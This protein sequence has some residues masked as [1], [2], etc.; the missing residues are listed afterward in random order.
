MEK[1][2]LEALWIFVAI[3]IGEAVIGALEEKEE[4][5]ETEE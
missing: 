4:E 3:L 1:M 2:I 5:E